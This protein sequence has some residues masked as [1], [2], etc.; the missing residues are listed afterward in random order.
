MTFPKWSHT[1]AFNRGKPIKRDARGM[2]EE[3]PLVE[4]WEGYKKGELFFHEHHIRTNQ[5]V[6]NEIPAEVMGFTKFRGK[7][8]ILHKHLDTR[9]TSRIT[10]AVCKKSARKLTEDE[11]V[12]AQAKYSL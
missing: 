6:R 1:Q 10:W 3:C 7:I 9:I 11:V 12:V 2:W 8:I 5:R 4:S